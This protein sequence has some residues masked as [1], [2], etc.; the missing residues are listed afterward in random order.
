MRRVFVERRERRD[1][2]TPTVEGKDASASCFQR[3]EEREDGRKGSAA[4]GGAYVT[5]EEFQLTRSFARRERVIGAGPF[6]Y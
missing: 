1:V 4:E 3:G 5:G 2:G 6:I